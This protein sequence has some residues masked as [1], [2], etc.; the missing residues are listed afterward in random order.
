LFAQQIKKKKQKYPA[1]LERIDKIKSSYSRCNQQL[2]TSWKSIA[3]RDTAELLMQTGWHHPAGAK[4][5]FF[6]IGSWK[7]TNDTLHLT[8]IA[9][10]QEMEIQTAYRMINLYGCDALLP[11]DSAENWDAFLDDLKTRFESTGD[12]QE[13]KDFKNSE[14]FISKLFYGFMRDYAFDKKLFVANPPSR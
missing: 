5:N 2:C 4:S 13:F 11:L 12:Y 14:Q 6:S 7:V 10:Y 8:V 1:D 9:E 3:L